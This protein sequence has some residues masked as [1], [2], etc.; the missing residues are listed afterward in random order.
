MDKVY[1]DYGS[2]TPSNKYLR[3]CSA[4]VCSILNPD[5]DRATRLP[6]AARIKTVGKNVIC[7]TDS[8][9]VCNVFSFEDTC[10]YGDGLSCGSCEWR[11]VGPYLRNES[12]RRIGCYHRNGCRTRHQVAAQQTDGTKYSSGFDRQKEMIKRTT[13]RNRDSHCSSALSGL[14]LKLWLTGSS[15]TTTSD[16]WLATLSPRH[17]CTTHGFCASSHSSEGTWY[18]I[19]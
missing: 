4:R 1:N 18:Q 6:L 13:W 5:A 3:L 8:R 7:G 17:S 19:R 9:H 15:S 16:R 2:Q 10:S 12:Y 11:V 14:R